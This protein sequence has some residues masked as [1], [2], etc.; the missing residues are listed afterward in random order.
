M[1][2]LNILEIVIIFSNIYNYYIYINLSNSFNGSSFSIIKSLNSIK[3]DVDRPIRHDSL[4]A[5]EELCSKFQCHSRETQKQRTKRLKDRQ[6]CPLAWKSD[7]HG[8]AWD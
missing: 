5:R 4:I 7:Y 1:F 2:N 3:R 6:P 8:D